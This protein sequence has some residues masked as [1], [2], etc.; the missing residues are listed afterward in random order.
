MVVYADHFC[1]FLSVSA[2]NAFYEL[3]S[4]GSLSVMHPEIKKHVA[5]IELFPILKTIY[6]IKS[7]VLNA[8]RLS[9]LKFFSL[10]LPFHDDSDFT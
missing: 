9:L 5:P 2:V 6:K 7:K 3:L 4:Q 1:Y 10:Q 8:L